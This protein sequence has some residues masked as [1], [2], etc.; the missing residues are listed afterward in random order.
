MST[1]P[2]VVLSR[3]AK[4]GIT[5]LKISP[6]T[7]VN[8]ATFWRVRPSGSF[9]KSYKVSRAAQSR[10]SWFLIDN[11]NLLSS[12]KKVTAFFTAGLLQGVMHVSASSLSILNVLSLISPS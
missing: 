2:L 12:V 1:S 9:A 11:V 8:S 6:S 5:G 7:P 4:K 10:I 3:S